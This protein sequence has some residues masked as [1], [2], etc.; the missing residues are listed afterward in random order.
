VTV[1]RA[2]WDAI[3]LAGGRAS[4]LDGTAKP[5]V[6]IGGT[7]LLDRTVAAVRGADHIVLAGDISAPGCISAVEQKPFGGP[8]A[9]IAAAFPHSRA[10]R[11]LVLA[12]DHPFVDQAVPLLVGAEP[13][14][15]GVVAIDGTG[16]RQH[17]LICLHRSSLGTALAAVGDP[18]GVPMHRLLATL[19]VREI[20]VNDRAAFDVDTW[21]D[22]V[23][24]RE[25]D[26]TEVT[27][28]HD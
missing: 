16:R 18:F 28:E 19:D 13:G 11:V 12:C 26:R 22:V 7:T 20:V 9:G 4:R 10:E 25:L 15:D 23:L 6:L 1:D 14:P 21:D 24:G 27:D 2:G 17:L 8:V 5:G 3:I